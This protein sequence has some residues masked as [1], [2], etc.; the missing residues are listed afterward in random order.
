VTKKRVWSK[1]NLIKLFSFVTDKEMKEASV[2]VIDKPIKPSLMLALWLAI[3]LQGS[4][5]LN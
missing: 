3:V 1:V 5:E 2:A 4:I